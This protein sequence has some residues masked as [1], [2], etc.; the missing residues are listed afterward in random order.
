MDEE[1]LGCKGRH[2]D[3]I[4]KTYKKRGMASNVMHCV[5]I[6]TRSFFSC[7]QPAPKFFVHKGMLP[8]HA[9][10]MALL[11]QLSLPAHSVG[12]ENLFISAKFIR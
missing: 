3:I 2:P 10:Y 7:N 4:R 6:A 8:L 11:E 12:M 9:R 1:T 5:Q